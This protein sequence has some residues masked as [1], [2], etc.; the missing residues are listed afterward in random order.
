[1]KKP[2]QLDILNENL[3]ALNEALKWLERSYNICNKFD[4]NNLSSEGMD[5]FEGL[6]S[7]FAR[8]SDILFNKVF[9]SITYIENGEN[10]PWI[11]VV[12][13]LE[14]KQVIDNAENA[15]LIKEL[16]NDIVH[17]YVMSDLTELYNE[18]LINTPAII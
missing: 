9:R 6:T 4:T 12:Y 17:E 8:V 1:M 16:R 2:N 14:K 18:F 3:N 11:D 13:H 5:A 15:R 7:R 10:L